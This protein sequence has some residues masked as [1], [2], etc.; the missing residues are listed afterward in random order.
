LTFIT[1]I[2]VPWSARVATI[3]EQDESSEER[4]PKRKPPPW[5]WM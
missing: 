3:R 1:T 2:G 4:V 5:R